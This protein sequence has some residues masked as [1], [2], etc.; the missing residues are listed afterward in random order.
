MDK[1]ISRIGTDKQVYTINELIDEAYQMYLLFQEDGEP[2]VLIPNLTRNKFAKLFSR[3]QLQ[4]IANMFHQQTLDEKEAEE[5]EGIIDE[6][7]YDLLFN[8][9]V[10]NNIIKAKKWVKWSEPIDRSEDPA[11]IYNESKMITSINEF[12]QHLKSQKVNEN[13]DVIP[14]IAELYNT[15]IKINQD[16]LKT[17]EQQVDLT[18]YDY[19]TDQIY[20]MYFEDLVDG[21]N[22]EELYRKA[23]SLAKNLAMYAKQQ[24]QTI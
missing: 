19:Y 14:T 17:G 11:N 13:I 16:V 21:S 20:N 18:D 9:M 6:P 23:E 10:M 5:T 22:D 4:E 15:F 1:I 12:K 7:N 2:E 8:M 3:E 24:G